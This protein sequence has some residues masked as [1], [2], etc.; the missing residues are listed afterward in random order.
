MSTNGDP[1]R[2]MCL[3]NFLLR[4]GV[5]DIR[6][7]ESL[8]LALSHCEECWQCIALYDRPAVVEDVNTHVLLLVHDHC[9]QAR[10]PLLVNDQ[11]VESKLEQVF[12]PL[13]EKLRQP[14]FSPASHDS[15]LSASQSQEEV[16]ETTGH[17]A[18][19]PEAQRQRK[20]LEVTPNTHGHPTH[21][22]DK[23]QRPG[24]HGRQPA[25]LAPQQ[26]RHR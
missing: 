26:A 15:G 14:V 4:H 8:Y 20:I 19:L 11:R 13:L 1:S 21:R 17:A 23:K 6:S 16:A 10:Q 3:G 9:K 2:C 22:K 25:L 7:L 5:R 18:P 24:R 12:R